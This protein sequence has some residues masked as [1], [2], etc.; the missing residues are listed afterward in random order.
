MP[1]ARTSLIDPVKLFHLEAL[2]L[3]LDGSGNGTSA[4][5]FDTAY[6]NV[7][8]GA[9]I[10]PLGVDGTFSLASLTRTG[11]TFTVSGCTDLASTNCRAGYFI[12]EK[13]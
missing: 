11:F 7:P 4:V 12:H 9:A 10:P 6:T 5:V 1:T 3:S 2:T 8:V 13:F